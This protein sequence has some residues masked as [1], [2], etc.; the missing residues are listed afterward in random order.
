MTNAKKNYDLKL[1]ALYML[2]FVPRTNY[3]DKSIWQNLHFVD[4]SLIDDQLNLF[5]ILT[6]SCHM[7]SLSYCVNCFFA[8]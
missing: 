8:F 5:D 4:F 1:F 7:F 6:Q 3:S 2:I